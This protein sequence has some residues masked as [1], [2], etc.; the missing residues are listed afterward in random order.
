MNR[1]FILAVPALCA[2]ITMLSNAQGIAQSKQTTPRSTLGARKVVLPTTAELIA[3]GPKVAV[4]TAAEVLGLVRGAQRST[5]AVNT[6]ELVGNGTMA[7]R[8]ADGTWRD[9]KVT[10]F[11]ES[12][13]F[14]IPAA[15]LELERSS[16]NTSPQRQIQVVAGKQ[17]WDEEKPGINGT[18]VADAADDRRREIWLTPQG[19]LWGALRAL[20]PEGGVQLGNEQGNLA[21]GYSL[22]GEPIK[23]VLNSALLPDKVQLQAHSA[24]YGDMVL[25]ANYSQYKDFEGYLFPCPTRMTYKAGA[26]TIRNVMITNCVVNPY[27]IFP[28]PANMKK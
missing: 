5:T 20:T 24:A 2:V 25:E 15:R 21:I 16:P 13:D 3:R 4:E 19:A 14:V 17:A 18:P 27:V 26:H 11:T 23:L 7:E 1:L 9:Y 22:N 6:M 28:M 10:R 12:F 8:A